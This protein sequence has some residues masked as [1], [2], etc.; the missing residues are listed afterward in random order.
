M[1]AAL[2]QA[3]DAERGRWFLWLPVLFGLGIALYLGAP[4]E[5]PVLL[6]AGTALLALVL[7][8]FCAPRS[9]G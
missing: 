6:A 2:E 9:S 4:A 7:R 8:M 5:P 1:I 3:L